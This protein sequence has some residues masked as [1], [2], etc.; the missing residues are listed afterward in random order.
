MF[1]VIARKYQLYQELSVTRSHMVEDWD[2][3]P[4]PAGGEGNEQK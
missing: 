2:S 1:G 4:T 3:T